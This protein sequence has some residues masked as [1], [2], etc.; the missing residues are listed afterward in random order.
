MQKKAERSIEQFMK[1][2]TLKLKAF[3]IRKCFIE[4]DLES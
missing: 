4:L 3:K 2:E 1:L